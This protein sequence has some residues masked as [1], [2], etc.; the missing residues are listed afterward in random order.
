[1]AKSWSRQL[2]LSALLAAWVKETS[3]FRVGQEVC[4]SG[5]ITC[6][7]CNVGAMSP[8]NTQYNMF[9]SISHPQDHNLQCLVKSE[10]CTSGGY[11]VVTR[12]AIGSVDNKDESHEVYC[13][14]FKLDT[15][16]SD[17]VAAAGL[18]YFHTDSPVV[19]VGGFPVSFA[20]QITDTGDSLSSLATVSL[21]TNTL[22]L[23][24]GG[25][26]NEDMP[27]HCISTSESYQVNTAQMSK[28]PTKSP[29]TSTESSSSVAPSS[30]STT[31]AFVT[32]ETGSSSV[33]SSNSPSSFVNAGDSQAA[34]QD[35]LP[36]LESTDTLLLPDEAV[37]DTPQAV[38]IEADPSDN[39]D[40]TDEISLEAFPSVEMTEET[41]MSMSFTQLETDLS[42]SS[43]PDTSS[44]PTSVNSTVAIST[45]VTV[46][47]PNDDATPG[48]RADI[49]VG[50]V[51]QVDY[52]QEPTYMDKE[53]EIK[54]LFKWHGKLAGASWGI[55]VPLAMSAAWFRESFPVA[56]KN[57]NN[58]CG[59]RLCNQAWLI[60]HASMA[61]IAAIATS[62]SVYFVVKALSLEGGYEYAT[63]FTNSHQYMGIFLLVGAW[64]QV[65]G[66]IF[67]PRNKLTGHS[68][69]QSGN[70]GDEEN[71][72]E[73]ENDDSSD[74]ATVSSTSTM[75]RGAVVHQWRRSATPSSGEI[76]EVECEDEDT[77]VMVAPTSKTR[78]A[79]DIG[80]RFMALILVICGFWQLFSGLEQYQE[81]YGDDSYLVTAC[82]VWVGI[83]WSG[84]FLLTCFFKKF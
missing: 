58:S 15:N 12:Y 61:V 73:Y 36:F 30:V 32:S 44:S 65:L 50:D 57:G 2:A 19:Q 60:I 72:M 48:D 23:N 77:V 26:A 7:D 54:E 33:P 64:V 81:R 41:T 25:C 13:R 28:S 11:E 75:K 34:P 39:S 79:W 51:L 71:T 80:H 35:S 76:A 84:T 83:F 20:G 68:K 1:M 63:Q 47:A 46:S 69:M 52:S 27:N 16:S 56:K 14:S 82:M 43:A 38:T 67:R 17:F 53:M 49:I 18:A 40:P 70:T 66:G 5:Y 37:N 21:D 3:A 6:I 22:T 55:L 45:S 9:Q 78:K 29:V 62:V 24:M 10:S 4:V 8:Y 59:R 31:D 42:P 74:S